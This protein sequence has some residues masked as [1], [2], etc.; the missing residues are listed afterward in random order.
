MKIRYNKLEVTISPDVV[1]HVINALPLVFIFA[2]FVLNRDYGALA[3]VMGLSAPRFRG[4][5]SG[6]DVGAGQSPPLPELSKSSE[7]WERSPR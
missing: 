4:S 6:G 1:I 7:T 3:L 2:A 5:G